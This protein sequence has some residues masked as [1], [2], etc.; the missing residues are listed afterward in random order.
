MEED[1]GSGLDDEEDGVGC[2][3][4]STPVEQTL[5]ETEITEVL[6]AGVLSDEIGL[7]VLP[8]NAAEAAEEFVRKVNLT[9]AMFA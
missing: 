7:G 2:P 5:L 9:V 3:L 8:H 1:D 6:K 4:P